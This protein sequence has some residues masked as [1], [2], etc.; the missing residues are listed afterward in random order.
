[1][2]R[3]ASRASIIAL[4]LLVGCE[5]GRNEVASGTGVGQQGMVRDAARIFISG[6]SL[7]DQ[8]FPD[9]LASI[10]ESAGTP[11]AWGRQYQYGS[12]VKVRAAQVTSAM[13]AGHD[14]L[15][16]TEQSGLLGS[17]VWNDTVRELRY[18]HDQFIKANPSGSTY[19]HTSWLD[20]SSRD[21]PARWIAHQR[22]EHV[23]WECVATRIN[24]SLELEGRPDR[25]VA[26]PAALALAELLEQ[27]TSS[28]GVAGVTRNSVRA[29]VDLLFSDTIHTTPVGSYFVALVSYAAI[30]GR[31]PEGA[32]PPSI[33]AET[34]HG[35]QR[36]AWKFVSDHYRDRKP[37]DVG[38]CLQFAREFNTP[39]W[40]YFRSTY[41]SG[42]YNAVW[43]WVRGTRLRLMG[44][45]MLSRQDNRNPL[46]FNPATDGG[47]WLQR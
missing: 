6:H 3:G 23:L 12:P 39:Y 32:P 17:M 34:A 20:L 33:P 5:R 21:D 10:G 14:A 7:V 27:A 28:Q 43:A 29:T 25:L 16:I 41:F 2:R 26:L 15:L 30:L 8:P 11:V 18:Y 44:A 22:R 42:S 35:L 4:F 47:Y 1:M 24:A 38:S 13:L 9:H 36:F 40:E 45:T 31:S 37:L 19:L 46:H